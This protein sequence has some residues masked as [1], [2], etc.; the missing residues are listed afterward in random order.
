[1]LL[2]FIANNVFKANIKS[3]DMRDE[4]DIQFILVNSLDRMA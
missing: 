4:I 1:M 3:N 2:N